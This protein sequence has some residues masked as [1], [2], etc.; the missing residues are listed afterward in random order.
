MLI[1]AK[2]MNEITIIVLLPLP[3][4]LSWIEPEI[5]LTLAKQ[6]YFEQSKSDW[7]ELVDEVRTFYLKTNEKYY[8]NENKQN[9]S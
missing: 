7:R 4:N 5:L 2:Y 1:L 9:I 8:K 3:I 6:P